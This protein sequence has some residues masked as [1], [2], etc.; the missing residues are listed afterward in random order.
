MLPDV[1]KKNTA[2]ELDLAN[3][4]R[5]RERVPFGHPRAMVEIMRYAWT[6]TM[7]G[8]DFIKERDNLKL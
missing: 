6:K 3:F 8:R 7:L 2:Y 4:S 1:T 5:E